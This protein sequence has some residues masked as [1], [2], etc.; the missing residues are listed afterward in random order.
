M[1]GQYKD[2]SY[3]SHSHSISSSEIAW[4]DIAGAWDV[5]SCLR[6]MQFAGSIGRRS[7]LGFP[8][9]T[10]S[11]GSTVTRGKR[12]AVRFIIKVL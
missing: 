8:T 5:G 9:G 11:S 7:I 10:N 3:K 2:D 1:V 4:S 6:G 12:K